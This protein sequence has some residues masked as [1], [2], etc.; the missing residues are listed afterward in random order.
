MK[1]TA[2][3]WLSMTAPTGKLTGIFD[4]EV[5]ALF[6]GDGTAD[7]ELDRIGSGGR[8]ESGSMAE[9]YREEMKCNL[10]PNTS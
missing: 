5:V 9:R 1:M 2:T 4:E 6:G 8:R 7:V 3:A 10:K